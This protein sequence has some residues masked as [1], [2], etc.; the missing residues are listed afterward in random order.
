MSYIIYEASKQEKRADL[1]SGPQHL[2]NHIHEKK[3]G[4]RKKKNPR[5]IKRKQKYINDKGK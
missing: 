4:E 5:C 1:G 3:E 2:Y